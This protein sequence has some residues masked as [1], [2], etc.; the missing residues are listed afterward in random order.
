ELDRTQWLSAAELENKQLEQIRAL[1]LHC[2]HQVPYYRQII[3][4]AGI[5]SRPIE[6]LDEFRR[7]PLLT[8]E[9]YQKHFADLQAKNLPDGMT[10]TGSSHTSGTSGVPIEVLRTNRIDF[11]WQ[12]FFLRDLEWCG[13]DPSARL[14]AIRLAAM[15]PSDLP[16]M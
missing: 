9:L 14:A 12:A 16:R 13:M 1:L 6:S 3:S 4:E 11:W 5:S 15:N 2:F 7:L 8:R 10:A